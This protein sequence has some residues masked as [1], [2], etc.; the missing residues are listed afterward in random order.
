M[1]TFTLLWFGQ[2]ISLLG[3]GMTWF[4]LTIWA[5]QETGQAS[6]LALVGFFSFLPVVLVSPFA[7]VFV[8]RWSR[9][10]IL[11]GSDLVAGLSTV[12]LFALY[13]SGNLALWHIYLIA[14]FTSAVESFQLPALSASITMMVPK[15]QRPRANGMRSVASSVSQIGAPILAGILLAFQ[16]LQTIFIIDI[17]TF[18]FAVLTLL[19]IAIPQPKKE[20]SLDSK[21]ISVWQEAVIGLRYILERRSLLGLT[22]VFVCLNF[23]AMLG[24]VVL[25]PMILARTGSDEVVLGTVRS[26]LGIGGLAGG[27]LISM[28]G[29]PKRKI[30]GTVLGI[31]GASLSMAALGLGQSVTVWFVAGFSMLF[32]I[33]MIDAFALAIQQSKVPPA[34]QGRVFATSRAFSQIGTMLAYLLSGFLADFVFEPSLMPGGP[35]THL[36]GWLVGTGSGA[37]MGLMLFFSGL[38]GAAV[39]VGALLYRPVRDIETLLPEHNELSSNGEVNEGR[40]RTRS[41]EA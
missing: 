12:L 7:G 6:A 40:V 2:L 3:T 10:A 33:P 11:I 35:L 8:D 28:W 19:F 4:A 39:G 25:D 22:I 30:Y 20:P 14:V 15:A 29:G 34:V 13:T 21:P 32:F 27:L 37:G 38:L 24:L 41:S 17:V 16:G 23:L 18:C 26:V 36:F 9:K 1:R 31:V 5:W